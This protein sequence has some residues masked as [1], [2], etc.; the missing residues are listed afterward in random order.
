L[1]QILAELAAFFQYYKRD[2]PAAHTHRGQR[3][4][5]PQC[6]KLHCGLKRL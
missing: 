5:K 3:R 1:A 2:R 6:K 4:F